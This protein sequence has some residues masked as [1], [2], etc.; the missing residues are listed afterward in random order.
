LIS[1]TI[2]GR[3]ALIP[4]IR[5]LQIQLLIDDNSHVAYDHWLPRNLDVLR[6]SSHDYSIEI[7]FEDDRCLRQFVFLLPLRMQL[8]DD[9]DGL[10]VDQRHGHCARGAEPDER[11]FSKLATRGA[12]RRSRSPLMS[13]KSTGR[14]AQPHCSGN[15]RAI[16]QRSEFPRLTEAATGSPAASRKKHRPVSNRRARACRRLRLPGQVGEQAGRSASNA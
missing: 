15:G 16:C 7:N 4:S 1:R 2:S 5:W 11:V 3:V 6:P 12:S 9:A 14:A 8:A 13:K 10:A